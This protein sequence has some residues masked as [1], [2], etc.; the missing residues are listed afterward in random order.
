MANQVSQENLLERVN[1]L[2]REM[3]RLKRDLLRN[4]VSAPQEEAQVESLFGSVEGGDVTEEMIEEA[5][6]SL[7]RPLGDL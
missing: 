5:K 3:E 4:I 1:L 6:K 2:E 7:F